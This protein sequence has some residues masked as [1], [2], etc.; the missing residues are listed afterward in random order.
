MV[1]NY[2]I[3]YKGNKKV[4][5]RIVEK[6]QQLP[7]VL[8][9]DYSSFQK[10]IK[11]YYNK[12][13]DELFIEKEVVTIL[14]DAQELIKIADKKVSIKAEKTNILNLMLCG[15]GLIFF[16]LTYYFTPEA[17][18][19][20]GYLVGLI[21]NG[22]VLIRKVYISIF[23]KKYL[24]ENFLIFLAV[25]G[26]F[27]LSYY[28]EATLVMLLYLVADFLSWKW[29][30]ITERDLLKILHKEGTT[31]YKVTNSLVFPVL[32]KEIQVGDTILIKPGDVIPLDGMVVE[33]ESK[34]DMSV[35]S[36]KSYFIFVEPGSLVKSGGINIKKPLHIAVTKPYN[37]GIVNS[38]ILKAKEA[39]AKK[40]IFS[41]TIEKISRLYLIIIATLVLFVVFLGPLIT[42]MP[43]LD[44]SFIYKGLVILVISCPWAMLFSAPIVYK[45]ALGLG[46]KIGL[47][48]KEVRFINS[49]GKIKTL[50]F[51]K[52]GILTTGVYKVD[53]VI[54]CMDI[55]KEDLLLYAAIGEHRSSHPIGKAIKEAF[56]TFEVGD[57]K[58]DEN[59]LTEYKEERGK[60]TVAVY[61]NKVIITGSE[62]F[63]Y[64]NNIVAYLD[65]EGS[66]THVAVDGEY[67]GAIQLSE[68]L[69]REGV[70]VIEN[71]KK[72]NI[73][74][75]VVLTGEAPMVARSVL[76]SL[77]IRNI[78]GD[79][80]I[81][82]KVEKVRKEQ[83][84]LKC[85]TVGFVGDAISDGFLMAAS[86]VSFAY[87][88]SDLDKVTNIADIVLLK[89]DLNLIYESIL[90][91]KRTYS[92]IKQN[93][94]ISLIIKAAIILNVVFNYVGIGSMLIVALIDLLVSL[95]VILNCFRILQSTRI[96]FEKKRAKIK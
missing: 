50:F 88:R 89:E 49:L 81:E 19:W 56:E 24:D 76:S 96:L 92:V 40:S 83:L 1:K 28:I 82:K 44:K 33:G 60:G 12:A 30:L 39:M 91:G 9:V 68:E 53:N 25:I 14:L 79:L 37:E 26:A 77:K 65:E 78:Y 8:K 16:I 59:L 48:I 31:T 67:I 63:L 6:I 51:T 54:P 18:Q 69:K 46:R 75:I 29:V 93:I 35:V 11:V 52:T 74:R 43:F 23:K 47:I 70:Q 66:L 21:L 27:L 22:K 17:F 90:L 86:D 71:L 64:D 2:H 5:L 20:I 10:K 73:N 62:S 85:K 36:N 41:K 95:L 42:D 38:L 57:G 72:L 4:I 94:T 15:I 45:Y 58:I 80:S 84:R 13:A 87:L 61:N 7:N 34:V 55:K 32:I 3:D